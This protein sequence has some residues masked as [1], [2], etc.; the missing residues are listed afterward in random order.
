S[1]LHPLAK[2]PSENDAPS[3]LNLS[4]LEHEPFI[5][6]QQGQTLRRIAD[7]LFLQAGYQPRIALET[8]SSQTAH[9]LAS[10][11]IGFTFSTQSI[12][13]VNH[14]AAH[15]VRLFTAEPSHTRTIA[16]AYRKGKYLTK[17]EQAFIRILK[18][19]LPAGASLA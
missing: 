1:L 16:V 18:E 12:S 2:R 6:L 11:G 10:I 9:N 8:R 14:T 15:P 7:S 5:L 17:Y 3:A 19:M 4:E 13:Q